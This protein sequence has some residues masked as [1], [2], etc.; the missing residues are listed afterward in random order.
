MRHSRYSPG[1]AARAK[2]YVWSSETPPR[3]TSKDVHLETSLRE[4][5]FQI[6]LA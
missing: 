3:Y 1:A 6:A 4:C 2:P 5:G